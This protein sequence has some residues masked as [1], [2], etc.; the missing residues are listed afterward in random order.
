MSSFW[1]HAVNKILSFFIQRRLAARALLLLCACIASAGSLCGAEEKLEIIS[2]NEVRIGE[3]TVL[4]IDASVFPNASVEWAVS[5]DVNPILL[6]SGGRECA[7]T[8]RNTNEITVTATAVGY[9]GEPLDSATLTIAPGEFSL[10]FSAV[11]LKNA[12]L[13]D[14]IAKKPVVTD[15]MP[16]RS[17]I[18]VTA[19][20][21]PH[22]SGKAVFTWSADPATTI[23][24]RDGST[25]V[26]TRSELGTSELSLS[27]TNGSGVRMADGSHSVS[28]S[29]HA[30][31]LETAA[32]N[33]AAWEDWQ[34]AR[35]L[36]SEMKFAEA[37]G[38]AAAAQGESPSDPDISDGFKAMSDDYNRFLRSVEFRRRSAASREEGN[39]ENAL[40]NARLAQA[41]WPTDDG[42]EMI[43]ELEREV[44]EYRAKLIR[45]GHLRET[46]EAYE[47]EGFLKEALEYYTLSAKEIRSDEIDRKAEDIRERIAKTEEAKELADE[48]A[49]LELDG[50]IP[51][52]IKTYSASIAVR[53]DTD[54]AAHVKELQD[55]TD[56]R[57]KQALALYRE[58]LDF[59]KKGSAPEA[60][61]RYLES[62]AL[63]E[64]PEARKASA[65][66][67]GKVKPKDAVLRGAEDFGIGTK[68]DAVRLAR[69]ADLLVMQR[70]FEEAASLYR[71]SLSISPD[72]EVRAKLA[73]AEDTIRSR[74]GAQTAAELIRE[75]NI[76]YRSGRL[77]EAAAKYRESLAAHPNSEIE[78]FLKQLAPQEP[79][80]RKDQKEQRDKKEV[81]PKGR[82]QPGGAN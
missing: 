8:P 1:K 63:W 10:K 61:H 57:R 22:F 77:A 78:A 58:G 4:S 19:E 2:Q 20:L 73:D 34:S 17:P 70:R 24:S 64:L 80:A 36:W 51:E 67:S 82:K 7:F 42:D 6:R 40:K 66:L 62:L 38:L 45:A 23:V 72:D 49:A 52:A 65:E 15:A 59:Q 16:I 11:S 35:A 81:R 43:R 50:K 18:R 79:P 21:S 69:S 75:G 27:V 74:R 14:P 41:V 12:A 53:P 54:T 71:K 32:K 48:A 30:D 3:E 37:I 28:V 55:T 29:I 56:R 39:T 47:Q 60:L 76:L 5:G 9:D 46:A 33:T 13:W 31:D 44:D 25:V 68:D 26:I